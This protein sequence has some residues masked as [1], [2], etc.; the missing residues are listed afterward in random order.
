MIGRQVQYGLAFAKV[1]KIINPEVPIIWG[2]AMPSSI[3]E[4]ALQNELVDIIV[5]G[6]GEI[7]FKEI[8]YRIENKHISLDIPGISY[9]ENGQIKHIGKAPFFDK[10]TFPNYLFDLINPLEYIRDTSL[11]SRTINYIS[12]Q[13]CPYNCGFCCERGIYKG[14]WTALEVERMIQDIRYLIDRYQINGIKFQDADFAVNVKRV[15]R[16][17]LTVLK[18]KIKIS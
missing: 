3:P 10:N 7:T 18:E 17:C 12:S 5:R 2:G 9:K 6:Q 13:G 15:K 1:V 14:Q 8:V 11:N 4:I 16:F